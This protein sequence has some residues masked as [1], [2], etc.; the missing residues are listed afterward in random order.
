MIV[1][2]PP[3]GTEDAMGRITS[4]RRNQDALR[5]LRAA[6]H[7]SGITPLVGAGLSIQVGLRGWE[8]FLTEI[9]RKSGVSIEDRLARGAFEEAA[10]V[11]LRTKGARW[12]EREM[13]SAFARGPEPGVHGAVHALPQLVSGP[14]VTTNYDRV[15]ESVFRDAG[16]P[17]LYEAWGGRPETSLRALH[18]DE[19]ILLKIHGDVRST[20]GRVLTRSE[21]DRYYGSPDAP[22]AAALTR[23]VAARPL[24]LL[25]C[26]IDQDRYLTF[27]RTAPLAKGLTHFAVVERPRAPGEA[28]AR[29]KYLRRLRIRPLWFG[30]GR[31]G[32][33]TEFVD[34]LAGEIEATAGGEPGSRNELAAVLRQLDAYPTDDEKLDFFTRRSAEDIFTMN[35]F[36]ADYL[37]LAKD[38]LPR[39]LGRGRFRD[40]LLIA[41]N[42]AFAEMG[43]PR[44]EGWYR[45]AHELATKCND[46]HL[47]QTLVVLKA[48]T[49]ETTDADEAKA[50]Y[51]EA[52]NAGGEFS[53]TP[54]HD[55]ARLEFRTGETASALRTIRRAIRRSR[56]FPL[57][58]ARAYN[59]LGR[60]LEDLGRTAEGE[61]AYRASLQ[62]ATSLGD[63]D[64]IAT[65]LSNL[66]VVASERRD[67]AAADELMRRA[68]HHA[69]LGKVDW[70]VRIIR[71][72][73]AF[74]LYS[75][76]IHAE[77]RSGI[78]EALRRELTEADEHLAD[79][80]LRADGSRE[81]AHILTSRALLTSIL[82][83][84][85]A[86]LAE[87]RR[88]AHALR[89][90]E[91]DVYRWTNAYN[92]ARI[93]ADAGD[94]RAMR[95]ARRALRIAEGR[96]EA[97]ALRRSQELIEDLRTARKR[98]VRRRG[99]APL[100][101]RTGCSS[102]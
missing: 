25:G 102:K 10:E 67:W 18:S 88:A 35:G 46:R 32:D 6:L 66:A 21:Y 13:R 12:F 82:V 57:Q 11:V 27:L 70:L 69:Q 20:E 59:T 64:G 52:S 4:D 37:S 45:R 83:G 15:L 58:Q 96:P 30:E 48:S 63:N 39:A 81:R 34:E 51:R 16:K 84:K 86:A 60:M 26:R 65:A 80:L 62:V 79:L 76:A 7:S 61:K 1:P 97:F 9:A 33:I 29:A 36:V 74:S 91:E 78:T 56:A 38:M 98:A 89:S 5:A 47:R 55:L 53:L 72:N 24:L 40:A 99:A 17:F 85:E 2:L 49:L 77:G 44:F 93:L 31:F 92:R 8:T 19:H 41:T 43:T 100:R 94:E 28:R 75:R 101:C 87:L 3:E 95:A 90:S 73:R 68:L 22:L 71:Q 23:I 50:L 54:L 14:V 42:C